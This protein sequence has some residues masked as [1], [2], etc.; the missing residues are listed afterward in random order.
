MNKHLCPRCLRNFSSAQRLDTHLK[1]MVPCQSPDSSPKVHSCQYCLK[2]FTRKDSLQRHQSNACPLVKNQN[3]S[4]VIST[5]ITEVEEVKIKLLAD[6]K[7]KL[8]NHAFTQEI[9]II[10]HNE[11]IDEDAIKCQ[12]L[13]VNN[14]EK[15][16]P[17][18]SICGSETKFDSTEKLVEIKENSAVDDQKAQFIYLIREREFIRLKENTYKIGRT[19]QEPNSRLNGY[20][21]NSEVLLF[22]KVHNCDLMENILINIF[23][24]KFIQKKEYGREYFAGDKNQM[25]MQIHMKCQE[26]LIDTAIINHKNL[27]EI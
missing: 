24:K 18:K 21:K 20:P 5:L 4:H 17:I 1:K 3:L 10:K 8:E 27:I 15:Y 13:N 11:K 16:I 9:K 23:K 22:I 2:K 12:L 19:K 14:V 7:K 25:I 26:E 6:Q